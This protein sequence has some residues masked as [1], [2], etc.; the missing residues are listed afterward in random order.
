M[1]VD[2][3]DLHPTPDDLQQLVEEGLRKTPRQLPA[4]LLYDAAGSQLFEE[5]CAQPEYTLTRTEISLLQERAKEIATSLGSGVIVEFGIGNTRKVAPLLQTIQPSAFIALEISRSA[6]ENT[7]QD[8]DDAHPGINMLGICCDHSNLQS[9]PTHPWLEGQRRIGFFPGSSLGNFQPKEAVAV[10]ARFR[11]LLDG[12][13]LLLGLDQPR[14]P[15]QLEAAYD[16]AA[17]VSAAFARNL[18]HRLNRDL[19]GSIEP[20]RFAYRASWQ[21]AQ[22]RIEMALVSRCDQTLQLANTRWHFASGETLITEHSVKYSPQAAA[23]LVAQAGW[24]IRQRWHDSDDNLS[25][26]CLEPSD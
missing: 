1:S 25:L 6:L 18:L 21:E 20:E 3:I 23:E 14:D 19:Q 4:W 11:Q 22:Q 17:G 5:I 9:L 13:P 26:H 8:L 15:A 10:L 16:D 24:S 7:L 2:L 12:G